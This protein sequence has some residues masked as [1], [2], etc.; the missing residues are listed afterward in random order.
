MQC[1]YE[2]T[3]KAVNVFGVGQGRAEDL[4]HH[5]DMDRQ[6]LWPEESGDGTMSKT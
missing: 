2:Y 6:G 3:E 4:S 5:D 1:S